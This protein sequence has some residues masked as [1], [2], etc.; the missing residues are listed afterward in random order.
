[1]PNGIDLVLADHRKVD[2]LFAQFNAT[3]LGSYAGQIFD[4][5]AAH[6]DAENGALYPLAL[7]LLGDAALLD[8]A[9]TAHS[10]VKKLIDHAKTL[11]G[12]PLVDVMALLQAAVE[13]HVQDEE[14]NLLPKLQETAT[15][16]QLEGL[17]ARWEQIKQRVG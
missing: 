6:D 5:L 16:A 17:A 4:C 12:A 13:T 15:A 3:P 14:K 9:E 11:E 2:A 8:R 1:M 7:G 10:G